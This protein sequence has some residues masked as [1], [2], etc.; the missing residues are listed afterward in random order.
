[1]TLKM[2]P[3]VKELHE[4]GEWRSAG[5]RGTRT[6]IPVEDLH[7]DHDYQRYE[8][9]PANTQRLADD[10]SW[11][12]LQSITVHRR[13]NGLMYIV[14]GQQRWLAAKLRGEKAVP[15]VVY[16]SQGK[17]HEAKEYTRLNKGRTSMRAHEKFK[18]AVCAKNEPEISINGFLSSRK[19]F[20]SQ[21]GQT[22]YGIDFIGTLVET[23]LTD[24]PAAQQAIDDQLV[25]LEG[26]EM[27]LSGVIH[28]GF[29]WLN[30]NKMNPPLQKFLPKLISMG[31]SK[32]ILRSIRAYKVDADK[33][34][35]GQRIAG[36]GILLLINRGKRTKVRVLTG[37]GRGLVMGPE[38]EGT[39]G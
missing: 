12:L 16:E 19:L 21:S 7:V 3:E 15:C 22:P 4:K 9:S 27:F 29:F 34:E 20:V 35:A 30:H 39:E 33:W 36:I 31:G 32:V 38:E 17:V 26:D 6:W 28:K 1:M 24:A 37:R 10:F 11:S 13:T 2:K 25:L 18:A 5:D 23:W 8:V 14:D